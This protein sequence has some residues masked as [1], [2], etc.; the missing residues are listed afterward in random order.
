MLV[1]C[2]SVISVSNALNHGETD[3]QYKSRA[4]K[5]QPTGSRNENL[6]SVDVYLILIQVV[7][8]LAGKGEYGGVKRLILGR[9]TTGTI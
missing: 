2:I 8:T 5:S 6:H 1:P 7:K 4:S 9:S 3:R